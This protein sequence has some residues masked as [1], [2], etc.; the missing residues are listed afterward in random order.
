[1]SAGNNSRK[2][3]LLNEFDKFQL[4]REQ[5]PA[6]PVHLIGIAL[7]GRIHAA[8]EAAEEEGCNHYLSTDAAG[9]DDGHDVVGGLCMEAEDNAEQDRK[10]DREHGAGQAAAV[11]V[12]LAGGGA[13]EAGKREACEEAAGASA[14]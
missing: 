3:L 4:R 9:A 13:D 8:A 11:V 2:E 7:V 1:M 10:A 5:W 14:G 6:E 12:E